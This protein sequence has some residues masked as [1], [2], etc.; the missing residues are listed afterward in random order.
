M[1]YKDDRTEAERQT[2]LY[3]VAGTDRVMSGW[4]GATGGASVAAWAC[5]LDDLPVLER[6]VVERSDMQRVRVVKLATWRPKAAHVHVYA[7]KAGH[8]CWPIWHPLYRGDV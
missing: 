7:P 8:P 4:G 3:A 5:T 1:I 6:W 2:L